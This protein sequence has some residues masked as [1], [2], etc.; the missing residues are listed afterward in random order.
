M[1][2]IVRKV[3]AL[4]AV[5]TLACACAGKTASLDP[6]FL[7]KTAEIKVHNASMADAASAISKVSGLKIAAPA[8]PAEGISL[9]LKDQTIRKMLDLLAKATRTKWSTVEDVVVFSA[10]DPGEEPQAAAPGEAM[11]PEQ[12]MAAFLESLDPLQLYRLSGGFPLFYEEMTPYQKSILR[13]ML[14]S[15][16]IGVTSTGEVL[17]ELP[18]PEQ[19]GVAFFTMPYLIVPN[20]AAKEPIRVRLDSTPYITLKRAV[21]K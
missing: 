5:L 11:T 1:T 17:R 13:S 15:P 16:T 4:S 20:P 19:T 8:E 6:E 7:E 18:A 2:S 14:S 9:A 12:G 21:G 3:F 10:L